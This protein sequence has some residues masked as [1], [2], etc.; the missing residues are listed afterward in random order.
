MSPLSIV[1]HVAAG[2]LEIRWQD[3]TGQQLSNAFLRKNC[4]CADCKAARRRGARALS[5]R[6][7]IWVTDI[8]PVGAYAV[9]LIFSDGHVRGI[10]PWKYLKSLVDESPR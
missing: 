1:N 8:I 7:E 10:F 2:I 9:Q 6:D 4:Q 3:G 5:E